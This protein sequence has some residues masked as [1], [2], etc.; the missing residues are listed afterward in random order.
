MN[1]PEGAQVGAEGCPGPF[2]AVTVHLTLAIPMVIPRPLM[3]TMADRGMG[4]RAAPV[5]LPFIGVQQRAA[6]RN[7]FGDERTASPRGRLPKSAARPYHVQ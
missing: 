5:A 7:I 3:Y 2:A 1:T 6:R 4:G